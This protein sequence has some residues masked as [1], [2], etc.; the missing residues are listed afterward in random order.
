M[1][2][3][4]T[5][6]EYL[7]TALRLVGETWESCLLEELQPGDIFRAVSPF[8]GDFIHPETHE[9]DDA[10]IA[11]VNDLPIRNDNNRNGSLLGAVGYGVPIQLYESMDDLKRKGLS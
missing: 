9:P 6:K 11:R 8:T 10:C 5:P 1:K 2:W 7:I 3:R 4:R